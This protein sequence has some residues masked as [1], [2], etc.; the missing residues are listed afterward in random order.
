MKDASSRSQHVL[1][2][3][4]NVAV[5]I[6]ERI[7]FEDVNIDLREGEAIE[8][9]G[10]NGAGKTTLIRMILA[11]GKSFDGGPIL[12]FWR[13]FFLIRRFELVFMSRKLTSDICLIR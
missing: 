9:R 3:A 4:E 5:G 2:R 7:L 13:Y 12:L 11:S 8:I 6:G 10:R 1:A